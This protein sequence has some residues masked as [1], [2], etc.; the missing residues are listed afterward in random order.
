MK[1]KVYETITGIIAIL[2]IIGSIVLGNVIPNANYNSITEDFTY[3][4]NIP[5][6]VSC[7]IGTFL[8]CLIFYGI[9]LILGYLEEL[10]PQDDAQQ[11]IEKKELL[12]W[13]KKVQ[14]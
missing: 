2:G 1:S 13:W 4:F 14:K 9:S 7:L 3:S 6:C 8:L 11:E 5:L 12:E 10:L